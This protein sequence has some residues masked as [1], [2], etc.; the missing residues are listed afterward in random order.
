MSFALAR[1]EFRDLRPFIFLGVLC[2]VVDLVDSALEQTDQNPLANASNTWVYFQ[3]LLSFAIG[4][5]LLVREQDDG[6]LTFLDGLPLTRT[7]MFVTK[8]WTALVV[9]MLYPTT[10]LLMSVGLHLLSRDSLNHEL[11]PNL[12]LTGWGLNA[13]G[14]LV[15]L[16]IG[17]MLGYFR[18]LAWAGAATLATALALIGRAFPRVLWV[19]P[20]E[21]AATPYVGNHWPLSM[22]A[23][24]VQLGFSALFLLVGLRLFSG[25]SARLARLADAMKRPVL[26]VIAVMVTVGMLFA[27]VVIYGEKNGPKPESTT[28]DEEIEGAD[29]GNKP[30]STLATEHYT[31]NY[32]GNSAAVLAM[33]KRADAIFEDISRDLPTAQTVP[34]DVDLS[35]SMENTAGTAFWNRIRI[36]PRT[37]DLVPT[38]AHE[39]TH[40][41]ANRILA[42]NGKD[43][44]DQ[45]DLFNEGLAEWVAY[46]YAEGKERNADQLLAAVV[47]IRREIAIED[48]FT[49]GTFVQKHDRTLVYPLGAA[50]IEAL[51]GRYGPQAPAKILQSLGKKDFP[52]SLSGH[53]LWQAAFQLSGFDLSLVVDDY[54]KLLARWARERKTEIADFPRLRGIVEAGTTTLD[55]RV[56]GDQPLPAGWTTIVRFRPT[57][58]SPLR[59]FSVEAMVGD[60]ATRPRDQLVNDTVCFQP[61]LVGVN[62]RTIYEPWQCVPV[63]WTQ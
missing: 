27:V 29:F 63:T 47:F 55:I 17:T 43:E 10:Q 48:L 26:S 36:A 33:S 42:D 60:R 24:G 53:A 15:G 58:S 31:F 44:L 59:D 40:V 5:G 22:K 45:M 1:K 61:G 23:I 21:L 18:N 16:S 38:L 62:Q 20:T 28:K 7:Q 12:L 6:T 56:A 50:F 4:T 39:S 52:S 25:G 19:D 37:P 8:V 51:V 57:S 41:L 46:R 34:I 9:L 32:D 2:F 14:A 30:H 11:H 13:L 54:W 35:G 49:F 3:L